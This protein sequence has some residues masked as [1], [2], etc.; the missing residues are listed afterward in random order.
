M[1]QNLYIESE[2]DLSTNLNSDNLLTN[3]EDSCE[4]DVNPKVGMLK[5]KRVIT[6]INSS[7]KKISK[8]APKKKKAA[9][10]GK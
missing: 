9:T 8:P 6:L 1:N 2:Q 7:S 4:I 3:N 10:K 5:K